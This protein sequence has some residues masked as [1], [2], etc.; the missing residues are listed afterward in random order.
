MSTTQRYY[1]S[2]DDLS[3]ARGEYAQ[4]SF[5]GISPDSFAAALQ[6]ALRTPALW[7]RWKAL[8]PDPDAVDDAMGASDAGAT[9]KAEQSDLHTEIEVV[10]NLPHS[11][12]K[13]RLNLLAG[14]T[15]KLH[16]VK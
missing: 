6:A 11:I 12:L 9:V 14:R 16:D 10:T 2:I 15:W 5:E 1:L 7:E 3:K 13:H 4:L 8:Q